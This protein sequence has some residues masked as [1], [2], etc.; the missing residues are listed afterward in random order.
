M[1]MKMVEQAPRL[2]ETKTNKYILY[3]GKRYKLRTKGDT[4]YVMSNLDAILKKI[5][6][7]VKKTKKKQKRKLI[8]ESSTAKAL[9]DQTASLLK[10]KQ[11]DALIELANVRAAKVDIAKIVEKADLALGKPK[12]KKPV[13]IPD[14]PPLRIIAPGLPKK[15]APPPPPPIPRR[16]LAPP[17]LPKKQGITLL[18]DE[19]GNVQEVSTARIRKI[20]KA[21]A[22]K[23]EAARA[24]VEEIERV[25]IETEE[26]LKKEEV[27]E[28][29]RLQ[30]EARRAVIDRAR[31]K[32]KSE[33]ETAEQERLK[34]EEKARLVAAHKAHM[35][36][37]YNTPFLRALAKQVAVNKPILNISSL[38]RPQLVDELSKRSN[39][40]NTRKPKDTDLLK[41]SGR[42]TK[43]DDKS[44]RV[45]L[46][47][48]IER[49]SEKGNIDRV[50]KIVASRKISE[51]FEE[52]DSDV[53]QPAEA[54]VV[55][56]PGTG[57]ADYGL[58]NT[59]IDSILKKYPGYVGTTS[60]DKIKDLPVSEKTQYSFIFNTAEFPKTG[61][62]VAVRVSPDTLEYFDPFGD[63]ISRNR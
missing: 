32:E 53:E 44:Q 27:A 26:R 59:Q 28:K 12:E 6:V 29:L 56:Q 63:Q 45:D 50:A 43:K 7:R 40:L 38:T 14:A 15:I 3:R 60:I 35:L 58:Y 4:Q 37:N 21:A 30:K 48:R 1:Y 25:R 41:A 39:F 13:V 23:D 11:Q 49:Q 33:R 19:F 17:S 51:H 2:I 24:L 55:G 34:V 5:L 31:E 61:H 8:T 42:P 36:I 47:E 52:S 46:N 22:E 10:Q 16:L 20:M 18:I 57:L 62:W 9:A 54:T